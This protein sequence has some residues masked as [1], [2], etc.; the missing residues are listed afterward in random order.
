MTFFQY[1][2]SRPICIV[3][4]GLIV[5]GLF[6]PLISKLISNSYQKKYGKVADAA[7]DI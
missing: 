6:S 5:I 3:L 4:L 2:L 1:V 7:E